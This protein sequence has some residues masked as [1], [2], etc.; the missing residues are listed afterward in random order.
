MYHTADLLFYYDHELVCY[1]VSTKYFARHIGQPSCPSRSHLVRHLSWKA[2]SQ[3]PFLD[4]Q[5]SWP[6]LNPFKQIAQHGPYKEASE[7]CW[8]RNL[9]FGT[10]SV[11]LVS[12]VFLVAVS[13]I[14]AEADMASV[15]GFTV[16]AARIKSFRCLLR[17]FSFVSRH[18]SSGR[19]SCSTLHR[20]TIIT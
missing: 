7:S 19:S 5:T 18:W 9:G 11:S 6:I 2:C 12:I 10:A 16:K 4:S 3:D 15:H 17:S 13:S 14:A 1:A 8:L 20:Q